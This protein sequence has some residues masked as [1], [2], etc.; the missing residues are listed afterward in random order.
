MANEAFARVKIDAQPASQ[1]WDTFD[2]NCVRCEVALPDATKA[3]YV[4]SDRHGRS[5]GRVSPA[6]AG[7][8]N[9]P[10]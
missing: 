1:G 8:L 6:L 2:V 9:S 5:A 4:L 10:L 3:D 7:E